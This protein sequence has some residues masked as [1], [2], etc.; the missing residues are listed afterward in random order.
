MIYCADQ[1]NESHYNI[2]ISI[3]QEAYLEWY[4]LGGRMLQ[5]GR[6]SFT[7]DIKIIVPKQHCYKNLLTG[8]SKRWW[9]SVFYVCVMNGT[10]F[11]DWMYYKVHFSEKTHLSPMNPRFIRKC[12]SVSTNMAAHQGIFP[13]SAL[14]T[15]PQSRGMPVPL[16][17]RIIKTHLVKVH[18]P[19]ISS[20]YPGSECLQTN[21]LPSIVLN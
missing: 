1:E 20:Q 7:D 10:N 12:S 18:T 5:A 6:S 16:L 3:I 9:W 19:R 11:H 15:G 21:S 13:Q 17:Y 4:G 8:N 14:K 2:I